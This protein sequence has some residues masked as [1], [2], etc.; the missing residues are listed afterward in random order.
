M[1]RIRNVVAGISLVA[2]FLFGGGGVCLAGT[3]HRAVGAVLL[4]LALA[5]NLVAI[6]LALVNTR[7]QVRRDESDMEVL[8]RLASEGTL[9]QYLRDID[10][11]G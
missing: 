3:P 5:L 11:G 9:R 2:S 10:R 1:S 6:G 4:G 7:S 8:R